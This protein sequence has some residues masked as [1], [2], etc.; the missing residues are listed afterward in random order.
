MGLLHT[1]CELVESF[2]APNEAEFALN[3][4]REHANWRDDLITIFGKTHLVPRRTALY[5]DPGTSYSYSRIHMEAL[6]WTP[7]LESLRERVATA[8]GS[9]FNT[10]LLNLYRDGSD[11]NG[12][13]ADDEPELGP[14]PVIASVSLGATR[15]MQFKR[16]DNGQRFSLDL[17]GGSLLVMSGDS[18]RD[19]LHCIPKRQRF[20]APRINLTY[21]FV[22][23]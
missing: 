15:T 2:I 5:G 14:E 17:R 22:A 13:H 10:V 7:L 12:W 6:P 18:Q 19:W 8:A 23:L 11:S 1:D 16:R 20:T 21:R 4:L 9:R 3:E